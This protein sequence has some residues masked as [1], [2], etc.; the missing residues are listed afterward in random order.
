MDLASRAWISRLNEAFAGEVKIFCQTSLAPRLDIL[1]EYELFGSQEEGMQ[2]RR[3][4]LRRTGRPNEMHAIVIGEPDWLEIPIRLRV[5]TIDYAG[6]LAL[7]DAGECPQVLSANAVIFSCK[8]RQILAQRRTST[9]DAY[10]AHL[11]TFGGAYMPRFAQSENDGRDLRATIAREVKEETK[12]ILPIDAAPPIICA[13]EIA[14]GFIQLVYLGF[15]MS[16]DNFEAAIG[17]WEGHI[18]T[19][20]YVDLPVALKNPDW[21]PSGKAHVLAWLALNGP[22]GKMSPRLGSMSPIQLFNSLVPF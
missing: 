15:N 16:V 20:R 11:H 14:T 5:R 2:R 9:G 19:I 6:I 13:K 17:N 21:V 7:R 8:L 18:E 1:G 22:G 3:E 10:Y 4:F 12:L